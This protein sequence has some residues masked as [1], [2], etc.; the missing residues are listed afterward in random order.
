VFV[1]YIRQYCRYRDTEE[2]WRRYY[3]VFRECAEFYRR[4]LLVELP[5]NHLMVVPL[6]D[7]D[8]GVYPVQDGPFTVC[9]AARILHTAW[10]VAER[11]G[12]QDPEVSEWKR[13][14]GMALHLANHLCNPAYSRPPSAGEDRPILA[15]NPSACFTD[16]ELGDIPLPDLAMDEAVRTW[17]DRARRATTPPGQMQDGKSNVTGEFESLP[18]WSWGPLQLAHSAATLGQPDEALAHLK[19]ALKTMMDFGAL[20]ESAKTDLSDVHHPWFTTAAGAY[21]R[22][23]TRMLLYTADREVRIAPGIPA[24]WREFAFDLPLHLGG[25]VRVEVRDGVLARLTLTER[26]ADPPVRRVHLPKRFLKSGQ[27][28]VPPARVA[29]DTAEELVIETGVA[30]GAHELLP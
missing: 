3:P 23:L 6:I 20:N 30:R 26:K 25:R 16:Y 27:S 13:L 28:F 1:N 22:A 12:I 9:G 15:G 14:G 17:R 10:S 24:A 21:L 19:N 5:G 29:A 18:F 4:W 11:L 8:E 2:V 7:V